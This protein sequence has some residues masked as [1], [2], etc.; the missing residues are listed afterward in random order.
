MRLG[1][2]RIQTLIVV[3]ALAGIGFAF[4]FSPKRFASRTDE[5]RELALY[6]EMWGRVSDGQEVL[7]QRLHDR[8][9]DS[10]SPALLFSKKHAGF[11]D[12]LAAKYEHASRHYLIPVSA[13]P[14]EPAGD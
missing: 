5:Y 12:R 4:W 3:I 13:D 2:C 11:H 10:M 9:H 14:A 6:D 8:L 1:T 7:H